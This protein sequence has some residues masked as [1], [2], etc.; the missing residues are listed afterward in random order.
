MATRLRLREGC[1]AI[2]GFLSPRLVTAPDIT[3]RPP[4]VPGSRRGARDPG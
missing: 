4:R 2:S 3:P 1:C